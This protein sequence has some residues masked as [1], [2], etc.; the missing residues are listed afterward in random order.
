MN[1]L[2]AWFKEDCGAAEVKPYK[3]YKKGYMRAKRQHLEE[4]LYKLKTESAI[5]NTR[6]SILMSP[7]LYN[8]AQQAAI[9]GY[10]NRNI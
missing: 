4:E 1:K 10:I 5:L 2:K 3:A 7:I 8:Y 6:M 9:V